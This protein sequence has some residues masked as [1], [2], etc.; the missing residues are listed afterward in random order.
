MLAEVRCGEIKWDDVSLDEAVR[1]A[2]REATG[3]G[4]GVIILVEKP[5]FEEWGMRRFPRYGGWR[6]Q[7]RVQQGMEPR[8]SMHSRGLDLW[9]VLSEI[10]ASCGLRLRSEGPLG[11]LW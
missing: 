8:V 7:Q 2:Q 6:N 3:E 10:A 1:W 9:A 11:I 4:L 5:T